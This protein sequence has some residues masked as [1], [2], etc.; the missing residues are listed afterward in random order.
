MKKKI[1]V[2][3]I[4]ANY[5]SNS[6]GPSQT[7]KRFIR[8]VHEFDKMN[9]SFSV[10]SLDN[11]KI[12]TNSNP[13]DASV[14]PSSLYRLLKRISSLEFTKYLERRLLIFA[15]ISIY[16]KY[17]RYSLMIRKRWV[18]SADLSAKIFVFHEPI[19]FLVFRG[20]VNKNK[21]K[22][23]LFHHGDDLKD[24]MFYQYYP[25]LGRHAWLKESIDS[26]FY[27]AL[28]SLDALVFINEESFEYS[29]KIYEKSGIKFYLIRNGIDDKY[30]APDLNREISNVFKLVT[31]GTVNE[32]KNQLDIIKAIRAFKE[33]SIETDFDIR[34]KVIGDGPL[35]ENCLNYVKEYNLGD[36]VEFS[37]NLEDVYPDLNKSN[38]Y[39]LA[40]KKEGL[41]I[42]ILEALSVGLPI[43]S[44][45]F[46]GVSDCVLEGQNGVI[47]D[48]NNKSNL[49][50]ILL[51]LDKYNWS[52]F[53][54]NSRV[55]FENKFKFADMQ[56]EYINLLLSL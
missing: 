52:Q 50:D 2:Q 46:N 22:V 31:V 38:I 28:K 19:T 40:S 55:L 45:N 49:T 15:I 32:R 53:G 10:L 7:L 43:I 30:R 6:I 44:S 24:N 23:I 14:E 26:Y 25:V 9:I 56:K 54:L 1:K 29:K 20:I 33:S 13:G 34:L 8:D 51:N 5:L 11:K 4:Y 16:F 17:I 48:V 3:T 47:F 35:L 18:E 39:I 12:S 21:Q 42:S 27:K 36:C 37:G 41:P